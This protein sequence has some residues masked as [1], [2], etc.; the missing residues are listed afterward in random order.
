M[1][2]LLLISFIL[3]SLCSCS[4]APNCNKT[5]S[6]NPCPRVLFI[7]NSYTS[8]NDLPGMFALLA[9]SGGHSVETGMSAPGGWTLADHLSSAQTLDLLQSSKWDF[10]ILQEQSQ[11]P[12]VETARSNGMYPAARGLVEKIRQAGAQPVFFLAWAHRDGW[13]ENKLPDYE[14]MQIQIDQGYLAIAHEL[15]APVAPVGYA[16]LTAWLQDP[17]VDLWQADNS[18]PTRQ[19]TYLAAC[20]FYA[21]IFRQS[22]ERLS[23]RANLPA[24]PANYLQSLAAHTVLD[25]LSQ[26]NLP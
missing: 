12:S 20:V 25:N 11:V 26:W 14:S 7:G 23:Y 24:G 9:K 17:H 8:V 16:W 13:P 4:P 22:P 5:G 18:H 19:G 21:V 6:F 15:S 3:F 2:R 10:V 1:K